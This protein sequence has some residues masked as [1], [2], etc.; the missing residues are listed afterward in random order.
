MAKAYGKC[1]L[2][3]ADSFLNFAGL[4]KKCNKKKEGTEIKKEIFSDREIEK[5]AKKKEM[6]AIQEKIV[7][8]KKEAPAEEAK[9][10]KSA[11]ES[12]EKAEDKKE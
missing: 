11:E 6:A 4:C 9:E 5:E 3:G 2:C 7:E 12:K 1:K 10:E 8:T